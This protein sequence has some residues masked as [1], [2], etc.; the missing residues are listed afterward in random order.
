MKVKTLPASTPDVAMCLSSQHQKDC[1][2]RRQ[3]FLKILS[4][5]RFLTHQGLPFRGHGDESESNFTQLLRLRGEDDPRI[6]QW[7]KK[8]TDKYTSSD[9]QNEILTVMAKMVVRDLTSSIQTAPFISIMIDET[10]DESNKEQVVICFRWVDDELDVHEDFIGLYE[11]NQL[12][13]LHC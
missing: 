4:N 5:V 13:L 1:L 12:K 9:I 11:Q 7:I 6:G 10:T 3:C 2:E 8:R